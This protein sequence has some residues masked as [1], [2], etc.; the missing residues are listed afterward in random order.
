MG[1]SMAR[2]LLVQ[3]L[4]SLL[5]LFNFYLILGLLNWIKLHRFLIFL[6]FY[7]FLLLLFWHLGF[8]CGL[9]F[10]IFLFT[11]FIHDQS[12]LLYKYG[13][14]LF[15]AQLILRAYTWTTLIIVVTACPKIS[16]L[17]EQIICFAIRST[18]PIWTKSSLAVCPL[19]AASSHIWHHSL[20][21]IVLASTLTTLPVELRFF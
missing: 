21:T 16:I 1:R 9:N 4:F 7:A 10:S 11:F 15:Y 14:N 18:N 17:H 12:L 2:H 20:H 19:K 3:S 6:V 8:I 5:F 13:F